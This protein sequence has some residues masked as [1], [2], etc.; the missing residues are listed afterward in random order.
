MPAARDAT[1]NSIFFAVGVENARLACRALQEHGR[2]PVEGGPR[3]R[4]S[5]AASGR[6]A[7]TPLLVMTMATASSRLE[8]LPACTRAPGTNSGRRLVH[9]ADGRRL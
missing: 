2:S 7:S 6:L 9:W 4:A 1:E 3:Q 8:V 5:L